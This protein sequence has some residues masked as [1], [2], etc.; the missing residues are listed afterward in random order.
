MSS[1]SEQSLQRQAW[2]CVVSRFAGKREPQLLAP[3][4]QNR[5]QLCPITLNR[6][7][8]S[9]GTKRLRPSILIVG[10]SGGWHGPGPSATTTRSAYR[11]IRPCL[12]PSRARLFVERLPNKPLLQTNKDSS[13][14]S[15]NASAFGKR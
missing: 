12:M 7:L 2:R 4:A 10:N 11:V 8:L 15:P 13:T 3:A 14:T 1:N 9:L 5:S 6:K